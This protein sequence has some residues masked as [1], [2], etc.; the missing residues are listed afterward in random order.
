MQIL[1]LA[2]RNIWRKKVRSIIAIVSVAFAIIITVSMRSLQLGS[3]DKMIEASVK[4]SGYIQVHKTEYWKDKSINDLLKRSD[5]LE[6]KIKSVE[7]VTRIIPRLQ[8][9]ALSAGENTSKAA[10]VFGIEPDS[11]TKFNKLS[12]R[13]VQGNY[14][15]AQSNGD[16]VSEGL[17]DYLK[18]GLKDTLVLIGQGYRANIA[19]GKYE[20]EGIIKLTNPKQNLSTVYLPLKEAQI[21]NSSPN[22]ISAYMLDLNDGSKTMLI[23]STLQNKLDGNYEIMGWADM[24]PEIENNIKID[25]T[26]FTLIATALYIIAGFGIFGTIIMMALE[27]KKE[28]GMLQANGMQKS[29][30]QTLVLYEALILGLLDVAIA[31]A[32]EIPFVNFMHNNPIPLTG[33][34]AKSFEAMGAEPVLQMGVKP[35]LFALMGGIVFCIMIVSSIFPA[36]FIKQ[37]KVSEAIK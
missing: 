11:E 27:R 33:D 4:N 31:F 24:A 32:I 9:F 25:T 7:G 26:I 10:M 35:L 18:L 13:V 17:A 2:C 30:I 36:W 28:F 1:K 37:M 20:I 22:L 19:A 29:Q 3:Y 23:K 8:N 12:D 6:L 5:D 21:F 15:T 34:S 16:L 14:L